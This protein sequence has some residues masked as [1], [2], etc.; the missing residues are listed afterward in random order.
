MSALGEA[1]A[2]GAARERVMGCRRVM[3]KRERR[4]GVGERF[5][6]CFFAGGLLEV[7]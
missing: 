3:A 7:G 4:G 2:M 1:M 5:I 6:I